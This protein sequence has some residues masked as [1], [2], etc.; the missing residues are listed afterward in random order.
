MKQTGS[1]GILN[2]GMV[3]LTSCTG[4]SSWAWWQD[5]VSEENQTQA[6]FRTN[7]R[8]EYNE[9][10]SFNTTEFSSS[11]LHA[12]KDLQKIPPEAANR[13]WPVI[14][15]EGKYRQPHTISSSSNQFW[16]LDSVIKNAIQL[17]KKPVGTCH[18]PSWEFGAK[19]WFP[20]YIWLDWVLGKKKILKE[21]PGMRI[22]CPGKVVVSLSL[23]ELKKT[24]RHGSSGQI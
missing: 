24:C 9:Q 20:P 19:L 23:E 2:W 13:L 16:V 22:G 3:L 17:P 15:M 8:P 5:R 18:L 7:L 4:K 11:L 12:K 6:A 1:E 10:A 21:H 14:K